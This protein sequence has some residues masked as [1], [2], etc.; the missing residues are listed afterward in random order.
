MTGGRLIVKFVGRILYWLLNA[1][2]R[3][4]VVI[5]TNL[6]VLCFIEIPVFN[7]NIVDPDRSALFTN[8]PF[9]GFQ[10]KMG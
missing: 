6:T 9:G 8:Y 3:L 5:R 10:T 2:G 1:G 7:E 4:Q